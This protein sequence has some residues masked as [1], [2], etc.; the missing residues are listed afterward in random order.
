M[1]TMRRK[2]DFNYF[3]YF[4]SCAKQAHKAAEYLNESLT[5]FH[6]ATIRDRL[7]AMHVIENDADMLR[8]DMLR[9]LAHEFMTPIEREDIVS[10]AQEL[11]NVVDGIEDVMQAV[12]MYNLDSIR[13]D[14]LQFAKLIVGCTSSLVQVMEQFAIFRKSKTINQHAIEV[15][16]IESEG[17][18]LFVESM[19]TLF[20]DQSADSMHRLIWMNM[21][22][23]L[24]QCLDECEDVVDII[25][26]VI[27]KNS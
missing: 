2:K 13:A 8:H 6:V 25:E 26:G 15:N 21:Y 17:D 14:T 7:T 24:E 23:R 12:Y 22:E 18:R 11:D 3:E 9:H 20:A 1:D 4:L 19:H 27:M 10:L 5:D 16:N